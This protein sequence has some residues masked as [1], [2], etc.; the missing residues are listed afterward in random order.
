MNATYSGPDA[1]PIG[2]DNGSFASALRGQPAGG[3]GEHFEGFVIAR[4]CNTFVRDDAWSSCQGY[5]TEKK[6][7]R[8]LTVFKRKRKA[9]QSA[10]YTRVNGRHHRLYREKRA[11]ET[12]ARELHAT[13]ERVDAG[14]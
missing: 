3:R 6:A 10:W 12:R 8:P 9:G 14:R 5:A 1:I 11:S 7:E 2:V 13:A 4:L